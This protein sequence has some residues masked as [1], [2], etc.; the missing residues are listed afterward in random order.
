MNFLELNCTPLELLF[1]LM[2]LGLPHKPLYLLL[3]SLLFIILNPLPPL[4]T[5]SV[6]QPSVNQ[7]D[8]H[9]L[10]QMPPSSQTTTN[11]FHMPMICKKISSLFDHKSP[12]S[13]LRI[14]INGQSFI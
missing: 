5:N 2:V 8:L 14:V 9:S 13:P 1:C 12:C 10:R 4:P 6:Q 11:S 7:A 3:N